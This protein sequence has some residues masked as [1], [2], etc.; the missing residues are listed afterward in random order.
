MVELT[1]MTVS[2][3][4]SQFA[5]TRAYKI[6]LYFVFYFEHSHRANERTNANVQIGCI[7]FDTTCRYLDAHLHLSSNHRRPIRIRIRMLQLQSVCIASNTDSESHSLVRWGS[8]RSCVSEPISTRFNIAYSH[9]TISLD[10]DNFLRIII[11]FNAHWIV[12]EREHAIW[13]HFV[14]KKR[15]MRNC[16]RCVCVFARH[17]KLRAAYHTIFDL[18]ILKRP[19][20]TG[21]A[22]ITEFEFVLLITQSHWS[23]SMPASALWRYNLLCSRTTMQCN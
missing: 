4:R 22:W 13:Y 16:V 2:L 11:Q 7:T 19:K 9:F 15:H 17:S 3:L 23:T 8:S 1:T 10:V 12:G 20:L 18:W 6:Q 21:G 5:I 14:V